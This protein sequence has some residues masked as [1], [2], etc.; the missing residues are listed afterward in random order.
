MRYIIQFGDTLYAIAARFGLPLRDLLAANPQITQPDL[1]F[2]GQVIEIPDTGQPAQTFRYVIRPGDTMYRIAQR[3]RISITALLAANPQIENPSQIVPGEIVYIPRRTMRQYVVQPGDTLYRIARSFDIS[4]QRLIE[5]NPGVDP[6]RLQI[7]QVLTIPESFPREIVIPREDYGY[8]EMMADLE[9]LVQQ[10]PFL[11]MTTIGQS[12]LGRSIPAVR[13]GVGPKEVH[14]NASFHANEYITTSVLM[15]FIE[16]YA[17]ALAENRS[18]G[19]FH[20]PTLYNQTS[21]WIVPMVNPDGVELVLEGITP[22]NPYFEE[23]LAINGGSRSFSGWKANIRGVDL[24]DQFPAN[25][26][27]EAARR[28]PDGPAPRDYP[29]PAPLSEPESQAMAQFTRDHDFRLII[30]FHTQGEVIYWGYRGLEPPEAEQIVR[31]FAEV[32]GYLPI[33]DVE[34]DAGYRDWF[35]QEYR[36][37]GFTVELG[38]GVNPLP[39]EQFWNIWGKT[40]GILLTGLVV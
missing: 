26:E 23:V 4:L 33:R 29:G 31:R 40:I 38:K 28:A 8:D 10:Y 17:Q 25:W 11:A 32:S 7:G 18:I 27:E 12:V 15:K 22:A 37:P 19:R 14:Y 20:I 9:A 21:L 6:T 34:S 30:A 1:I 16:E 3:F 5:A 36:R 24:N 35:I 2:P 39:F 13:L